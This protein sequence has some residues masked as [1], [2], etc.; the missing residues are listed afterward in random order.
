MAVNRM[1]I[2]GDPSQM[3]TDA[4]LEAEAKMLEEDDA[5]AAQEEADE[6]EAARLQAEAEKRG[7]KGLKKIA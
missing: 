2:F 3:G 6:L 7:R 5:A 4:E 1:Q